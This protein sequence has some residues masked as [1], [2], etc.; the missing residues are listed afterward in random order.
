M[1]KVKLV[2]IWIGEIPTFF[3][4]FWKSAGYNHDID[5][6]C[7]TDHPEE[8]KAIIPWSRNISVESITL[9]DIN[10]RIHKILKR[11][12]RVHEAYKLCDIRPFIGLLFP[13]YL[14]GYDYWGFHDFDLIFGDLNRV[15]RGGGVR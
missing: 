2:S 1:I 4:V 13:E 14:N 11:D 5:F 7:F 9:N 8:M 15:V 6:I 10:D 12:F 3:K